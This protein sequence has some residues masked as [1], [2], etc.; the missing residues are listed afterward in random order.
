MVDKI[1]EAPKSRGTRYE[2]RADEGEGPAVPNV[3]KAA[4]MQVQRLVSRPPHA[5]SMGSFRAVV[6]AIRAAMHQA[7]ID[8][9]TYETK[10]DAV[11]ATSVEQIR[12]NFRQM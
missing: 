11:V 6:R 9:H 1:D 8:A 2:R 3:I 7:A 12:A 10:N 5:W 4:A